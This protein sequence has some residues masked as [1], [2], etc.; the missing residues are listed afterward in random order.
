MLRNDNPLYRGNLKGTWEVS[1]KG[2]QTT[3]RF[4]FEKKDLPPLEA[5]LLIKDEQVFRGNERYFVA[6][7]D[8]CK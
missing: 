1:G 4:T 5:Q 6:K 7:S 2:E 8:K 3:I